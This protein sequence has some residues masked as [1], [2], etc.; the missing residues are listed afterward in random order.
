MAENSVTHFHAI[1]F[2]KVAEYSA[3]EKVKNWLKL[4]VSLDYQQVYHHS[5]YNHFI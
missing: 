4:F 3:T 1:F 5:D 2:T